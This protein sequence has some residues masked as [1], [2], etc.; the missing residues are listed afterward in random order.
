M[1]FRS[2]TRRPTPL[3]PSGRASSSVSSGSQH[4]RREGEVQLDRPIAG[5]PVVEV[6]EPLLDDHNHLGRG[7]H[8]ESYHRVSEPL[9]FVAI[10]PYIPVTT[11]FMFPPTICLYCTGSHAP[12]DDH[13]TVCTCLRH[14]MPDP[15]MESRAVL[16]CTPD[17]D[18]RKA[19]FLGPPCGRSSTRFFVYFAPLLEL[20]AMQ[21]L[22]VVSVLHPI[23]WGTVWSI[24]P[25]AVANP[26]DVVPADLHVTLLELQRAWPVDD[27]AITSVV[28]GHPVVLAHP[29][30][31]ALPATREAHTALHLGTVNGLTKETAPCDAS[32][33]YD[34]RSAIE[35]LLHDLPP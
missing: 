21:E 5:R 13:S 14:R 35:T 28:E 2:V 12:H 3:N 9:T 18:L 19:L 26:G 17:S 30:L 15:S 29:L 22:R 31:V 34:L 32:T 23:P 27:A 33:R 1:S 16:S 7:A 11:G 4:L 10:P 24:E 6:G 25:H 8:R 20:A